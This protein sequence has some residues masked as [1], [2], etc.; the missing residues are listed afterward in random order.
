MTSKRIGFA[1]L[2]AMGSRM[3][4]RLHAAGYPLTVWN[5]SPAA[6][7]PFRAN[8]VAV[9]ASP[10]ELAARSDVVVS[11]LFDDAAV[12]ASDRPSVLAAARRRA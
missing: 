1:G 6:A 8:G 7:E 12:R 5:R 10:A 11:M 3:A 4:R 2:G 9:A